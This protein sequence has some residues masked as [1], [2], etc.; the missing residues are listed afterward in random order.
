MNKKQDYSIKFEYPTPLAATYAKKI[1][2]R[3]GEEQAFQYHQSLRDIYESIVKYLAIVVL[4]QYREDTKTPG[5]ENERVE[6]S[7]QKLRRPSLGHWI[8]ILHD[9]LTLYSDTSSTLL[10]DI[11][12][13][14]FEKKHHDSAVSEAAI[15][16]QQWLRLEPMRKPPFSYRD[17][18]ELLVTY[19]NR[20][21]AWAAH[22]AVLASVREYQERIEVLRPALERALVDLQFL[23]DYP[24]VYVQEVR[25]RLDGT[26]SHRLYRGVGRDVDID[27]TL[28]SRN[29]L[30]P[31]HLYLCREGPEG[32]EPFLDVYPLLTCKECRGC[33]ERRVFI[34]NLGEAKRLEYLSYSCGHG[35]ELEDEPQRMKDFVTFLS[36]EEWQ[37]SWHA[38]ATTATFLPYINA[39]SEVLADG[40]IGDVERQQLQFLAKVLG[41]PPDVAD[42]LDAQVRR[43]LFVPAPTATDAQP[44]EIEEPVEAM[45]MDRAEAVPGHEILS[46][47]PPQPL[48]DEEIPSGG[49]A[50]EE[51]I[52]F[53]QVETGIKAAEA[54]LVTSVEVIPPDEETVT[55][56]GSENFP[57]LPEEIPEALVTGATQQKLIE[58]WSEPI[59]SPTIQVALFGSPILAFA[60]GEAGNI[61]VHDIKQRIIYRDHINSRVSR[62]VALDDRILTGTWEGCLYCYG[63]QELL[64]QFDLKSPVSALAVSRGP[65]QIA[66]GTWNGQIVALQSNGDILWRSKLDEGISSLSISKDGSLTVVGSYAGHLA[67]LDSVGKVAWLRDMQTGIVRAIFDSHGR[68]VIVATQDQVLTRIVA[69]NQELVWERTISLSPLNIALSDNDRRLLLAARNGQLVIYN[70]NGNLN[71]SS[72]HHI[73]ELIDALVLPISRDGNFVLALS[74]RDGLTFIDNRRMAVTTETDKPGTCAAVSIDGRYL[75]MGSAKEVSLYRL[76]QPRLKATLVPIG[77]LQKGRFTRFEMIVENVGERLA[78]E[79]EIRLEGP[80]DCTPVYVPSE[81]EAGKTTSSDKQSLQPKAEGTLPIS[82]HLGCL[83]D[84][85]IRHERQEI[86]MLDIA[87]SE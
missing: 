23:T 67:V 24:L 29:A 58:C 84:L 83:D 15:G 33:N 28:I 21:E 61:S 45:P 62:L 87:S 30:D 69:D 54:D 82:M 35:L 19:R 76:A 48:T 79:I 16:I 2:R 57:Q 31:H 47:P 25:K 44:T 52:A 1:S 53:E 55:L 74:R 18:F 4:A 27:E 73:E 5:T 60:A 85:G 39:L 72:E 38:Q 64:W 42:R 32:L 78:R 50:R 12:G 56:P 9:T 20:R 81:L 11:Y 63:C 71:T 70:V 65:T 68:D 17:L 59:A 37:Q 22:G 26:W 66:V 13:F 7:L 6:N 10:H 51:A 36:V 40:E 34:L 75:A 3:I 77:K 80:V 41:I 49:L 43:K 46:Q 8:S 86:L 14:Y